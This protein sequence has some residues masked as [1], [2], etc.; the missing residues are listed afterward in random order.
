MQRF[1]LATLHPRIPVS[2]TVYVPPGR[3]ESRR[4]K[5]VEEADRVEFVAVI[6]GA[7]DIRTRLDPR[8]ELEDQTKRF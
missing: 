6:E 7:K 4:K 5:A 3:D 1:E 2:R 8:N